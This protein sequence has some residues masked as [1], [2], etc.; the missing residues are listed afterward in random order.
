[1]KKTVLSILSLLALALGA[2]A[3]SSITYGYYYGDETTLGNI[4]YEKTETYDVALHVTDAS[5]VGLK[6]T[7]VRVPIVTTATN[8]TDYKVW[9][10]KELKTSGRDNAADI[11][12]QAFTPDGA[13]AEV[14]LSEPYTI[15]A[16]GFYAGYSFT[17][18]KTESSGDKAP[19]LLTANPDREGFYLHTSRSYL[20]WTNMYGTWNGSSALQ[21]TLEGDVKQNAAV[22]SGLEDSYL[23]AGKEQEL[24]LKIRNHGLQP[25]SS[26]DYTFQVGDA[27]VEKHVDL[28]S[29]IAADYYGRSADVNISVPAVGTKGSYAGKL[30]VTKVN[31]V[32]NED[33]A[34]TSSN[35]FDV[36][37]YLP[38]HRALLEEYTGTWCGYCPRGFVGLNRM[39]ELFP[40][41][42]IGVSYHNADPMEVTENFPSNVAGFPDAWIDRVNQTDAYCGDGAYYTFGIDKAWQKRSSVVVPAGIDVWAWW[43]DQA[44]TSIKVI[45]K[46]KFGK[47]IQNNPYRVAY[48]LTADGLHGE[49]SAWNQSNYYAGS[50]QW[51]SDMD[52]FTTGASKVAGLE[53][54]DVVIELSEN[55]IEGSLPASVNSGGEY[56]HAYTFLADNA[57]SIYSKGS[58]GKPLSLIQDP[59]RLHVVAIIVDSNTGEVINANKTSVSGYSTGITQS[60]AHNPQPTTIYTLDGRRISSGKLVKGIYIINGRKVVVK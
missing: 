35:L 24:V 9:L 58:D 23:E 53:Y 33:I 55:G 16:D 1:M 19:V 6:V 17:I 43:D 54:N 20:K 37:A 18:A 44:N 8:A 47:D 25:V 51:P 56:G 48:I 27:Q 26:F 46:V 29:A 57:R 7:K 38:K 32:A 52:A 28:A 5:L 30:T 10:T 34:P 2:N 15:T 12:T 40:D 4:G 41:D 22:L 21:L 49:E 14:T 13:W 31:G 45:S 60:T 39:N 59:T 50:D 11:L 36:L 42:F 3:Q